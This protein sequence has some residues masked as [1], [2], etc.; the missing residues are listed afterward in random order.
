MYGPYLV[1]GLTFSGQTFSLHLLTELEDM[2]KELESSLGR[3]MVEQ[4]LSRRRTESESDSIIHGETRLVN[5]QYTSKVGEG[6]VF[7]FTN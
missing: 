2:K 5:I 4:Q 6:F 7:I 3:D 1:F